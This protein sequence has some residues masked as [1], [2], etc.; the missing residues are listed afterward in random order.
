M[1]KEN[2]MQEMYKLYLENKN[3][4]KATSNYA[5]ATLTPGLCALCPLAQGQ[6][7]PVV[8]IDCGSL[9]SGVKAACVDCVVMEDV[10]SRFRI[11]ST[12]TL[13]GDHATSQHRKGY[14]STNLPCH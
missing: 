14:S 7:S 13:G 12:V 1:R 3:K 11:F 4:I 10:C 2:E 9:C 6:P 8:M 5:C